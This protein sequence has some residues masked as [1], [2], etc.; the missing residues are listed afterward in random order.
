MDIDDL[1][2]NW[3]HAEIG[4]KDRNELAAITNIQNHPQLK[5]IRVK[6]VLEVV[7]LIIFLATYNNMFD[8]ADKPLWA[9]ITL[10]A[11]VLCYILTDVIGYLTLKNPVQGDNLK[12]SLHLFYQKL[13][14]IR[15][16]S[17]VSSFLFGLAVLLFFATAFTEYRYIKFTV[18]FIILLIMIYLLHRNWTARTKQIKTASMEFKGADDDS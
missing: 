3:K 7:L 17:L 4:N 10:F 13:N 1:K 5:S 6:L 16:F 18:L 15:L 2:S 11:A 8:G 12:S 14:R 9:N